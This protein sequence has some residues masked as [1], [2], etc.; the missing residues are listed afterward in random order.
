MV[1]D[2]LMYLRK[3]RADEEQSTDDVLKKHYQILQEFCVKKFGEEMPQQNI[4]K[5]V[6][7]GETIEDRPMMLKL[8]EMIST[9]AYKG[10][11]VVEPQRLSR[12]NTSQ[13][14]RIENV[15][16]YS[17][18]LI[19][20]PNGDYDLSKMQERK[21]LHL[22]LEQGNDYLE[23]QKMIMARG[24]MQAIKNGNY[25]GSL[26]PLGYDKVVIDKQKTL[27]P[28]SDAVYI[29]KI[30]DM[31]V[32]Q[33]MP[34][35]QI[36]KY[37]ASI[38]KNIPSTSIRHILANPIYI[39]KVRLNYRPVKKVADAQGNI[40]KIRPVSDEYELIDGIHKPIIETKLFEQAQ[41]QIGRCS[42]KPTN[43]VARNPYATIAKC[44]NC[45][46]S[47][48]YR[49]PHIGEARL[50]CACQTT[51]HTPSILYTAFNDA[52]ISALKDEIQDFEIK[53]TTDVQDAEKTHTTIINALKNNINELTKQQ[54][55]LYDFLEN[56][57]YSEA[58]FLQRQ[59]VLKGKIKKAKQSLANE[60][61]NKPKIV[62]YKKQI[63]T[64]HE[65]VELLSS[66]AD[67]ETKN[68]FLK[69]FI[70]KIEYHTPPQRGN[71]HQQRDVELR[72]TFTS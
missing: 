45:G 27:E 24:R 42:R 12:G 64:L 67:N 21:F 31:Y 9:G 34:A 2:Y 35:N 69:S 50:H 65:A 15:F 14:G 29:Q 22:M 33:K 72:I 1:N 68:N 49:T 52:V 37:L 54:N 61:K 56:G 55:R 19:V 59:T 58:V 11:I 13:I 47:L 71:K 17:N 26:A 28:N 38:G 4:L 23:Y 48:S 5:E 40:S 41:K 51:C 3:S 18:T 30:F 7:S 6:V 63:F 66:D 25:I 43:A 39:G 32:N 62:D 70:D 8:L 20:T 60:L 16:Q 36:A 57:T 53:A 44:G 10:V 46:H